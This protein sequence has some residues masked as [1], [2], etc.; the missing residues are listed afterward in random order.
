LSFDPTIRRRGAALLFST[1]LVIASACSGPAA[2]SSPTAA[3]ASATP[4]TAPAA[5]ATSSAA[6]PSAAASAV[7]PSAAPSPVAIPAGWVEHELP[8]VGVVMP[9][10]PRYEAISLN[11]L[12]DPAVEAALRARYPGNPIV[13]ALIAQLKGGSIILVAYDFS[14]GA[15]VDG[16]GTQVTVGRYPNPIQSLEAFPAIVVTTLK[17][18]LDVQGE[19]TVSRDALAIGPAAHLELV[20]R[21]AGASGSHDLAAVQYFVPNDGK[22]FYIS[23]ASIQTSAKVIDEFKTAVHAARPSP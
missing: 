15:S 14:A 11:D 13:D 12:K 7:P 22:S 6:M 2:P 9:L 8:D 21:F 5:A 16:L 3:A 17:K 18:Q 23:F 4:S 20:H 10:P 19:P 1:A